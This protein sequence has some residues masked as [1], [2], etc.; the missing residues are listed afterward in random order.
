MRDNLRAAP[1]LQAA[2][3]YT[4]A[5]KIESRPDLTVIIESVTACVSSSVLY[6]VPRASLS[7]S[8]PQLN[9]SREK[10]EMFLS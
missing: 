3:Q 5:E 6:N 7:Y 4:A 1:A 9:F 8:V 2:G 10:M